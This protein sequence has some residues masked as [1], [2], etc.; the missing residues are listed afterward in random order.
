M[1]D[2]LRRRIRARAEELWRAA[3]KPKGN[4]LEFWLQAEGE[5]ASLSVAGEEDPLAALDELVPDVRD[6]PGAG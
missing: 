3:G 5:C 4:D 6:K 1:D 2:D